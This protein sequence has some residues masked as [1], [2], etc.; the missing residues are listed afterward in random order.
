MGRFRNRGR[1]GGAGTGQADD[2]ASEPGSEGIA[3]TRREIAAG[4]L[5]TGLS[6]SQVNFPQQQEP[7]RQTLLLVEDD[8]GIRN[9]L[10]EYLR[11]AGYEIYE[12]NSSAEAVAVFDANIAVDAVFSDIRL[13]GPMDGVDLARWIRRRH[14]DVPIALASGGA[15]NKPRAETVAETFIAKPYHV[16]DVAALIG[17]LLAA[18]PPPAPSSPEVSSEAPSRGGR[19]RWRSRHRRNER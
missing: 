10:A 1:L 7:H 8:I 19:R 18:T 14:P 17:R 9:S 6:L 5:A 12:A 3:R 2:P 15:E 13:A 4:R 11:G 16:A